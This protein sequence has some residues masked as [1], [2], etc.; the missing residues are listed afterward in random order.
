MEGE[1]FYHCV[2]MVANASVVLKLD[3]QY[4]KFMA[5]VAINDTAFVSEGVVSVVYSHSQLTM[6]HVHAFINRK[7]HGPMHAHTLMMLGLA[8]ADS[9]GRG[10]Q[11][12]H[13][14]GG[15]TSATPRQLHQP[16]R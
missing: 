11:T 13:F 3:A 2:A 7:P 6:Q 12:S 1:C 10:L 15:S 9:V 4:S 8:F 16:A 14:H 5:N